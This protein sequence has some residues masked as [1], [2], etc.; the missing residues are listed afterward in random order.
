MEQD[1]HIAPTPQLATAIGVS[2][3]HVQFRYHEHLYTFTIV[4]STMCM[5][6][7]SPSDFVKNW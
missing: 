3:V 7:L 6:A 1:V 5:F 2:K 4:Y